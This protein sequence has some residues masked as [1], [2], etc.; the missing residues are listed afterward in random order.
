M[1]DADSIGVSVRR[2]CLLLSLNRSTFYYRPSILIEESGFA[3]EINEIWHEMP[4][5][6][7]RR[8][9]AE[10]QRRGN[11]VNAKR[12]L[13]LMG[14]MNLKAI[15]PRPRTTIR[16]PG[17]KIY[18]YLLKGLLIDAPNK[19]WSTDITYLKLPQGFAYLVALID[20][21]SRFENNV[22]IMR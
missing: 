1:I 5:Y 14:E 8:I 19:A 17:H 11:K 18:P 10:L 6:G 20:I 15:Y 2:Q 7:Y 4:F 13:R 9:T 22:F 3:N 16:A 21:Y 12:V